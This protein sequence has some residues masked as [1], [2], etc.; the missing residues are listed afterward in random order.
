MAP[1]GTTT[2]DERSL[3]GRSECF[4][5]NEM[6]ASFVGV[7]RVGCGDIQGRAPCMNKGIKINFIYTFE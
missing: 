6:R 4:V 1:R 7:K 5:S 2:K 3:A